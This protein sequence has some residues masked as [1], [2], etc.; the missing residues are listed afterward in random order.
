VPDQTSYVDFVFAP[1][2]YSVWWVT[3][4]V[5]V[6]LLVVAWV[7]GVLVWTLPVE[8]LRGIPVIRTVTFKVLQWKF[9]RS[10]TKVQQRHQAGQLDT[11]EAFHEISRIFRLFINFR[12]GYAAREMTFT[13]IA[14]SPLTSALDVLKWTYP[15]QFDAAD[16]RTV[17]AAV[18]AARTAVVTWA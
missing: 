2:A 4:A 8:V 18:E 15:G 1:M 6:V 11:R 10:L 12:T 16:P 3:G 5:F 7:I 14:N 13:D 17:S 9:A